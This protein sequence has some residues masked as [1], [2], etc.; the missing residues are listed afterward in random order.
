MMKYE[1]ISDFAEV[2]VG[3]VLALSDD[4][5]RR[6]AHLLRRVDPAD[7]ARGHEVIAPVRFKRGERIEVLAGDPVRDFG[8][9]L[10]EVSGR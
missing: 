4:Q 10:E 5:V 9:G 7:P 3:F 6:R 1:V 8:P 2:P